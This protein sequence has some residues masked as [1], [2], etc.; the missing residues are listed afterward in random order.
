[1]LSSY[2]THVGTH[3]HFE[4]MGLTSRSRHAGRLTK[5]PSIKADPET[6]RHPGIA[7]V[8][9]CILAASTAG[10][11][12]GPG[13]VQILPSEWNWTVLPQLL[14][15]ASL[16][17]HQRK[18]YG[19]QCRPQPFVWSLV[20]VEPVSKKAVCDL[21]VS[22]AAGMRS[23]S[24]CKEK[25]IRLHADNGRHSCCHIEAVL[26]GL[27]T[28]EVSNY[29]LSLDT[30]RVQFKAVDGVLCKPVKVLL[31]TPISNPERKFS[32]WVFLSQLHLCT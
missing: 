25:C 7:A 9:Q 8:P 20:R 6:L 16:H 24:G 17:W 23:A 32:H 1:M 14:Q 3:L 2:C 12:P 27:S 21:L 18:P 29:N 10:H 31:L 30:L 5:L 26:K 13:R 11:G 22:S 15:P 19:G 4:S 28:V